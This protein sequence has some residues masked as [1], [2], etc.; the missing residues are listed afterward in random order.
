[1]HEPTRSPH[2]PPEVPAQYRQE[3]LQESQE[4]LQAPRAVSRAAI[5]WPERPTGSVVFYGTAAAG[6][7]AL[8]SVGRRS[9]RG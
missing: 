4:T 7:L 3:R 1:M 8:W 5:V 9:R 6:A 2:R